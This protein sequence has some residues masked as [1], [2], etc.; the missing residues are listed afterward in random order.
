LVG[1]V[2]AAVAAMAV[3]ACAGGRIPPPAATVEDAVITQYD[4]ATE[5]DTFLA[6][7]PTARAAFEGKSPTN[8]IEDLNRNALAF[9]IQQQLIDRYAAEQGIEV[10]PQQLQQALQQTITRAGGRQAV[11]RQLEQRGLT[12]ADVVA[13]QRQL[14]MR[15]AVA[16]S[17]TPGG[18]Q[19]ARD[20]AFGA[21][22]LEALGTAA[23]DVNPRFG[24]LDP[25]LGQLLP[26][27]STAE[28]G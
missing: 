19:Q 25:A 12:D 5:V 14:A 15:Q 3:S 13:Y 18:D 23:I 9:L 8:R 28:L 24:A 27:T 6:V 2:V 17:L 1:T 10:D 21:W 4:L 26:I 7:T 11:D 16:T 22:L 20:Q